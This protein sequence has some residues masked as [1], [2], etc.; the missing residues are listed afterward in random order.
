LTSALRDAE[1]MK[2]SLQNNTKNDSGFDKNNSSNK[3]EPD[4]QID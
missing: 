4:N 2:N 3:E 1:S